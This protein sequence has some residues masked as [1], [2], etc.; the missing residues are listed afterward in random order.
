MKRLLRID[1]PILTSTL[2]ETPDYPRKLGGRGLTS[3]RITKEV[4]PGCD[5]HG[6]ENKL[7]FAPGILAGTMAPNTGRL[8]VSAKSP[9]T[10]GIKEAN[11][12]RS[13]AQ[14]LACLGLSAVAVEGRAKNLTVLKI[15]KN[16]ATFVPVYELATPDNYDFVERMR[17]ACLHSF[18]KRVWPRPASS[19]TYP[20]R[21]LTG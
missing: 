16:G 14:R 7:I 3:S 12:G 10:K 6:L 19:S 1:I 18:L 11:A 21:K 8:S 9:L 2:E 5:P 4:P 20:K 17:I 15:D 13:P